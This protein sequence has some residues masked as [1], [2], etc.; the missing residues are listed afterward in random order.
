MKRPDVERYEAMAAGATV[1]PWI[2]EGE[3]VRGA[4]G[5]YLRLHE[6]ARR[7]DRYPFLAPFPDTTRTWSH[8]VRANAEFIAASRTAI[9]ELCEWIKYLEKCLKDARDACPQ[10]WGSDEAS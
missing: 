6:D 8:D 3:R 5:W 4:D 2:T 7:R 10:E 9:P 1:G